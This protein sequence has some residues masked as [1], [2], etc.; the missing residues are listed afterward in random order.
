MNNSGQ[1]HQ[2]GAV[3]PRP[4]A[5]GAR[6]G[7]VARDVAHRRIQL[8]QRDR[9]LGGGFGHGSDRALRMRANCN[10]MLQITPM[11]SAMANSQNSP[12]MTSATPTA[13]EPIS[14]TRPICGS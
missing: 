12:A 14:L 7:G 8:G 11:R 6:L 10:C 3:G 1:H 13:A 5:R 2:I 9:E 4:S